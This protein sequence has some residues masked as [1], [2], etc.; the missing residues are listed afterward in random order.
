[1]YKGGLQNGAGTYF[2]SNGDK[3]T[4][5]YKDGLLEGEAVY[6]YKKE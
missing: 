1:M 3:V 2:H 6:T 4:G 5:N